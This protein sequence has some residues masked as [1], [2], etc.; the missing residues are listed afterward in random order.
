[1]IKHFCLLYV[2]AIVGFMGLPAMDNNNDYSQEYNFH[3][4]LCDQDIIDGDSRAYYKKFDPSEF[5]SNPNCEDDR[6]VSAIAFIDGK[7]ICPDANKIYI[8]GD[9]SFT[10]SSLDDFDSLQTI[11]VCAH[12][13][14][15]MNTIRCK[16]SDEKKVLIA[17][18]FCSFKDITDALSQNRLSWIQKITFK[19]YL[20]VAGE[21][22]KEVLIN[23]ENKCKQPVA[24]RGMEVVYGKRTTEIFFD[25]VDQQG[26]TIDYFKPI[27]CK[28]SLSNIADQNVICVKDNKMIDC[29][30]KN[31]YGFFDSV[32]TRNKWIEDESGFFDL[33]AH[34]S[35]SLPSCYSNIDEHNNKFKDSTV[36]V[37]EQEMPSFYYLHGARKLEKFND[38]FYY[39]GKSFFLTL[40]C[41]ATFKECF[42]HNN[43][44][45]LHYLEQVHEPRY[46]IQQNVDI[47]GSHDGWQSGV[48]ERS[49][50]NDKAVWKNISGN[51]LIEFGIKD[52]PLDMTFS[53]YP[54]NEQQTIQWCNASQRFFKSFIASV[55]FCGQGILNNLPTWDKINRLDLSHLKLTSGLK[56]KDLINAV[57]TMT[58]LEGL[59]FSY[60]HP[61][62]DLVDLGMTYEQMADPA[63]DYY[64]DFASC[65]KKLTQL[66]ELQMHGLWLKPQR[67]LGRGNTGCVSTEVAVIEGV[68]N[69]KKQK[70]IKHILNSICAI[71]T[72]EVCSIDG[73][74]SIGSSP[75]DR[76]T[77]GQRLLLVP[78]YV[79]T[80]VIDALES[81]SQGAELKQLVTASANQL[82]NI[83]S[84][85]A[86]SVYAP[87][88]MYKDY[89]SKDFIDQLNL[90]KNT[91][92][93]TLP[94]LTVNPEVLK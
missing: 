4:K 73:I 9:V 69:H 50:V 56:W 62:A 85:K 39:D 13:K 26:N 48:Y 21:Y 43:K 94:V 32:A 71:N 12:Y 10:V 6:W 74:P 86:I 15:E 90:V 53:A 17:P 87:Q 93:S 70:G 14:G 44:I 35:V 19:G 18:R 66:R 36:W 54:L 83:P 31:I 22:P 47:E 45:T 63:V 51:D 46:S 58:Q 72:L 61:I 80:F 52:V 28:H 23:F 55:H 78:I 11:G 49:Y 89:L 79:M 37:F 64:C 84:L 24:L 2:V 91:R 75:Y 42:S 1:M 41:K 60:N 68:V 57:S 27:K 3:E 77:Y 29:T 20:S 34:K 81:V 92:S 67:Y 38:C 65:I 30:G 33:I 7:M 16:L 40:P 88:G 76:K 5:Q 59:N 8:D 25:F 82:A